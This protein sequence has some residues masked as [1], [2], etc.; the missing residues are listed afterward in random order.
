MASSN[1]EIGV[2]II[3]M[4]RY[5]IIDN[6]HIRSSWSSKYKRQIAD[7]LFYYVDVYHRAPKAESMIRPEF[8]MQDVFPGFGQILLLT[9]R[10]IF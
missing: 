5:V 2:F 3:G 4:N 6:D 7:K 8:G 10:Y 9:R 1:V